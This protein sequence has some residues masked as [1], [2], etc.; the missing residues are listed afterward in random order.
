MSKRIFRLRSAGPDTGATGSISPGVERTRRRHRT[1]RLLIVLTTTAVIA[2]ILVISPVGR[3]LVLAGV[4]R[5]RNEVE[6]MILGSVSRDRVN[7]EWKVRRRRGLDLTH[8][9]LTRFYNG[10]TEEMRALFRI[11]EMDPDHALV[12]Y[13]RADQGFLLSPQVF[14]ADEKGRSYRLRP[15]TKSVWLRQITLLNGPFGLFQVR[16]TPEIRAAAGKAGAIV[17]ET[18]ITTTN[19]WGL[20]GPE[21]DLSA[22]IR[23]IALGDSFMQGMFN[24]DND[25]PPLDLQRYLSDAWKRPVT[26]VNTG[27]IGYSPEQYYYSLLEYGDRV[28]PWFVIISVCPNDFG[29]G[30]AVIRGEGD[31]YEEAG[32]WLG[33]IRQW[34]ASRNALYLV[35][36]V[37]TNV[38][39]EGVRVDEAYP[40][41]LLRVF[42]TNSLRYCDPLN[43]FTDE[44]LRRR[45]EGEKRGRPISRCDLFN[46]QINDDH[47]SPVGARLW[48]QI[49]GRRL[50]LLINPAEP[51]PAYVAPGTRPSSAASAPGPLD[52]SKKSDR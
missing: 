44:F 29:D 22:P 30:M 42:R 33:Q 43:E 37:P 20:R 13:G 41:P 12:R 1:F 52:E 6:R 27:H 36:P 8:Q 49:V 11:T 23:G 19:S 3:F 46:Y 9:S 4:E 15:N 5:A 50:V 48:A 38:Q 21:P 34:C 10:T 47:F 32:Y 35:V 7:A 18:S 14:A 31:W 16:D 25:T 26:V 17:D 24:G 28:K 40:S 51:P 39:I 2:A 45:I